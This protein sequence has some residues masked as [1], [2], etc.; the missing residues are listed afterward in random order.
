MHVLDADRAAIRISQVTEDLAQRGFGDTTD[1]TG[2]EL[3]VQV[4]D[5]QSIGGGVEFGRH[6][7]LVPAQRVEVGDQV[8]AHTVHANERGDLHLLVEHRVFGVEVVRVLD[9]LHRLVRHADGREHVVV[10]AVLPDQQL[11]HALQEQTALG[12]LDDAV[13]IGAR[14]GDDLGHA[15][16]GQRAFIG[17][18][19]LGRIVDVAHSDDDAL[20]RHKSRHRLHG[21]DGAGIGQADVGALEVL[22]GQ[23]VGLDLADD[24]VVGEE[25]PTEV[26]GV[27]IAQHRHDECAL[28]ATLVDVD[29]ET[30][31]DVVVAL[32]HALAVV[33]DDVGVLHVR[34]RIGDCAHDGVPDQVREADL[35]LAGARAIVVEHLAVDLEQLGRH[36]AEAR[37]GRHD[38]GLV[39]VRGDRGRHS[40]QGFSSGVGQD[41]GR[42]SNTGLGW[43][44]T[45]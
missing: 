12:T 21:A 1:A 18:L 10:E 26:E 42:L 34:H 6:L 32:Q 38:E 19:E 44:D 36:V 27:G 17:T 23:L 2:Q 7:G 31:V 16:L 35:G 43:L 40:A 41:L 29:G 14:D 37:R 30:D 22:D 9:P 45:R 33:T 28:A 11:V 15:D 13:V 20:A 3:A 4:P 39:H 25:E 24:L 5:G 8:S